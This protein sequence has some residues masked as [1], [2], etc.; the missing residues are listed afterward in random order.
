M[1]ASTSYT[2]V[3]TSRQLMWTHNHRIIPT[4]AQSNK[5]DEIWRTFSFLDR[6][7]EMIVLILICL[8]SILLLIYLF[9]SPLIRTHQLRKE[10][11]NITSLPISSMPLIGNVHQFGKTGAEFYQLLLRLSA[12]C[13]EEKKGV[14]CLWYS[15]IPMIFLSSHEGLEVCTALSRLLH[16][17][18]V[19]L[20]IHQSQQTI[21]QINWLSFVASM[22]EDWSFN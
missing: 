9:R 7:A 12:Q 6:K 17:G 4:P 14:F 11:E 18:S 13:Q 21:S 19:T 10:Y 20:E 15:T 1:P 16:S 22:V 2:A 3:N 8:F 5:K